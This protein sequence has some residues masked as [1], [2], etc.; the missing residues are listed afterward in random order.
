MRGSPKVEVACF[1]LFQTNAKRVCANRAGQAF[2]ETIY[3]LRLNPGRLSSPATY[4]G[5]VDLADREIPAETVPKEDLSPKRLAWRSQH[6]TKPQIK[7]P[8]H[9][10]PRSKPEF[11]SC[12]RFAAA[13]YRLYVRAETRWR[14]AFEECLQDDHL[15]WAIVGEGSSDPCI[16]FLVVLLRPACIESVRDEMNSSLAFAAGCILYGINKG[17]DRD[18]Q[19]Q[20]KSPGRYRA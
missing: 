6:K 13:V 15:I 7:N 19:Y 8:S 1:S 16:H 2:S 10:M 3:T 9:G 4:V 17:E 11:L 14:G 12:D 20:R 5:E 18:H